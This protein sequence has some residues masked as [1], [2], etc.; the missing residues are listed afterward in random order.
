MLLLSVVVVVVD[1]SDA[2]IRPVI[3]IRQRFIYSDIHYIALTAFKMR[4]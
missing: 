3:Y 2:F 4:Y 1:S